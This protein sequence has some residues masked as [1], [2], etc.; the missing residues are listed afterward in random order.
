M[1]CISKIGI[2]DNQIPLENFL[3]AFKDKKIWGI[4]KIC[5]AP[6][7]IIPKMMTNKSLEKTSEK[8]RSKSDSGENSTKEFCIRCKSKKYKYAVH[9]VTLDSFGRLVEPKIMDQG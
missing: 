7:P 1:N 2:R 3:E 8:F 6:E 5:L 9:Q 4:E